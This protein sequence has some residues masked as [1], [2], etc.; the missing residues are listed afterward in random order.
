M[1]QTDLV[2]DLKASLQD[3]ADVFTAAAD[4]DFI[5]HLDMAAGDLGR[6]RPRTL[7]GTLTLTAD[8]DL[9]AA[10]A[11]IASFK[12]HLWGISPRA[13]QKPWEKGYPGRLP[14]VSVSEVGGVQAISLNPPP[15]AFQIGV[16][17]SEFRYYYFARHLVGATA[18]DTTVRSAD[19]GLLLL[20]AQAEAMKEMAMRN[21][22][23]PVAMRDGLASAPRNGTPSALYQA[24]MDEF[25][26]EAAC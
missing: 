14:N 22:K 21:I 2:A 20:R 12:S 8:V 9:Y 13:A 26:K 6:F 10:P 7:V 18:A 23:K 1:S 5:R 25:E 3:A 17:G 19:R 11:D 15:T 24:L 16:L 4:A